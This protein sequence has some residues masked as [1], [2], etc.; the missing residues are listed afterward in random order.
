MNDT[1]RA[2]DRD[3]EE[4]VGLL[5][6]HYA[7]GRL[8]MEEFDER[9]TRAYKAKT[10]GELSPLTE[11]LPAAAAPQGTAWSPARM[12]WIAVAAVLGTAL[13]VTLA[14]VAGHAFFALPTWLVVLVAIKLARRPSART[15]GPVRRRAVG[16]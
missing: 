1:L 6:E 9:S 11:D 16:R 4:V 5:R 7:Q 8:T 13:V 14:V 10:M 12:R 3:R 2:A 15:S